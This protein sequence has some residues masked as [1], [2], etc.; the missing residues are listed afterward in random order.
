MAGIKVT[1]DQSSYIE[2]QYGE[3]GYP[4]ICA[5]F[6]LAI[7]FSQSSP[8]SDFMIEFGYKWQGDPLDSSN[9][10]IDK[11]E[12]V[13]EETGPVHIAPNL[14]ETI[15]KKHNQSLRGL[16]EKEVL[17]RLKRNELDIYRL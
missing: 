10:S 12:T 15:L 1:L 3:D 13:S 5:Y 2:M 11:T 16:L 4:K 14:I 7:P 9:W 8:A 17:S 6:E